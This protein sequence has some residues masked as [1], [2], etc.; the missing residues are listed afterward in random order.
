MTAMNKLAEGE[1]L[2]GTVTLTIVEGVTHDPEA[3]MPKAQELLISK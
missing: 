2:T 1:G 3:L